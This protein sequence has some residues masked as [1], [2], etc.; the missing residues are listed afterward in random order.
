MKEYKVSY[1]SH[2]DDLHSVWVVAE[3][4]E[5]AKAQVR[6]EYCD[7]KDIVMVSEM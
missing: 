3:N 5:E 6:E 1:I 4:R 7:I 2:D